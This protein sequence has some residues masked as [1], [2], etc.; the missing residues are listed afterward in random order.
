MAVYR[1]NAPMRNLFNR[2]TFFESLDLDNEILIPRIVILRFT[3]YNLYLA[4]LEEIKIQFLNNSDMFMYLIHKYIDKFKE[5]AE[6][7]KSSK[8]IY[9]VACK[10]YLQLSMRVSLK[11]HQI[12]KD[13]SDMTG[14]S[15]SHI[16]RLMIEWEIEEENINK[17]EIQSEVSQTLIFPN[18]I[19][20]R[21]IWNHDYDICNE[22]VME[23]VRFDYG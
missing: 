9:Q 12:L 6:R 19:I 21:I 16:I 4:K 10:N 5:L 2:M 3:F 22:I 17:I 23:I 18:T 7:K 13:I 14:Y 1:T 11:V 20:K 8:K 15:I